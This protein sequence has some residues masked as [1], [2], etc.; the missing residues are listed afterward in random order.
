M[1][2][3]AF[4]GPA[5]LQKHLAKMRNCM[6]QETRLFGFRHHQY[7]VGKALSPLVCS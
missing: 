3:V 6:R 1:Y 5:L 2:R 7:Q 4:N